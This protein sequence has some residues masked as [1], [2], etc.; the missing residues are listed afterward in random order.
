MATTHGQRIN[1]LKIGQSIVLEKIPRGGSLEARRL[2]SGAVQMY[3]R[4][5]TA[6][7]TERL[8]IGPYDPLAPPKS[9]SPSTRGYSVAAALEAAR[10][11][12]KTDNETPGGLRAQRER[13]K[14]AAEAETRKATARQRYTLQ[15]LCADYCAWLKKQGKASYREAQTI[16][17]NHLL[18]AHPDLAAK[19]AAEV[20]KREIVTALRTLTEAGKSTTARKLR[21]YLRAAYVCAVRADSDAAL[22]SS[23]IGYQVTTNPVEST[24]AIKMQPDK[25]PLPSLDLRHYWSALK[26]EDGVIGAALRLHVLTGGQ[27]AAQLTRLRSE[28]VSPDTLK[29]LDPKGKRNEPRAHLLPLTRPMRAEL[30]TL[31]QQGFIL[32]TDGGKTPMH[33]TSL[34]TW[35]RPVAERAGVKGFQLKRV[36]SGIETILAEAGIPLH[37]RGQ[38]QSH[39]IGGVQERHYDAHEYLQEKRQALETLYDLLENKPAKNVRPLR[40]AT[41]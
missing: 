27:R 10:E 33:A 25:N 19:P 32:S 1:E 21:S 5:T 6:G 39:G 41:S 26:E 8:P 24:A 38:L 29:L 16:F 14:A 34:S 18:E 9:L 13:E 35:S 12:A 3:W 36:R 4:H 23:F 31:P 15:A 11:H 30:G 17:K 22:P 2:Q 37:I 20:E 7:R 40:G 28:D